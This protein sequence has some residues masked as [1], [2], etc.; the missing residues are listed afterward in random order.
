L[1]TA[2]N[3]DDHTGFN[4]K[5]THML[6]CSSAKDTHAAS[7]TD[8]P[9]CRITSTHSACILTPFTLLLQL[10]HSQFYCLPIT[11]LST[12]SMLPEQNSV[13]LIWYQLLASQLPGSQSQH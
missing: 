12:H 9:A 7:Y 2:P 3:H 10:T 4:T 6:Y 8:I 5:H 13:L 11:Q 1:C